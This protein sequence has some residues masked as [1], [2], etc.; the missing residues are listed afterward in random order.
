MLGILF[1]FFPESYPRLIIQGVYRMQTLETDSTSG[2]D[3]WLV[4]RRKQPVFPIKF[5]TYEISRV[6]PSQYALYS[7]IIYWTHTGV[8]AL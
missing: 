1:F 4:L 2:F 7:Y 5:I 6:A 8:G 3:Y